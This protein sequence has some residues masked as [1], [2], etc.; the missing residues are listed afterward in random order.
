MVGALAVVE[1][2]INIEV[3]LE[4]VDAFVGGLAEGDSEELFFEGAVEAFDEAVGFR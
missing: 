4:L 1:I 3:A 2:Q